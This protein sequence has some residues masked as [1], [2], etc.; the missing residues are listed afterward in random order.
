MQVLAE[1]HLIE[2]KELVFVVPFS[3]VASAWLLP[4]RLFESYDFSKRSHIIHKELCHY[5]INPT[6]QSVLGL[7]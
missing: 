6:I 4:R 2:D 1:Y 5:E 7:V 3:S